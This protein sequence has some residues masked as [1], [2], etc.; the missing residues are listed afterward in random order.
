MEEKK[1]H[2]ATVGGVSVILGAPCG[3]MGLWFMVTGYRLSGSIATAA[4][5]LL[6]YVAARSYGR[7]RDSRPEWSEY[8]EEVRL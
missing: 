2:L 8:N 1:F 3:C 6:L 7:I 5:A 4:C